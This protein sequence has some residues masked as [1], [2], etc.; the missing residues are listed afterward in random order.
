MTT[1]TRIQKYRPLLS[2]EILSLNIDSLDVMDLERRLE[3]AVA[4]APDCIIQHP[5]SC[6]SLTTCGTFCD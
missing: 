5:C 3:M 1:T 4:V 6:T 2:T